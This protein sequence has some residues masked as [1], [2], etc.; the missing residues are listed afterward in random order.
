M[1][2]MKLKY[3]GEVVEVISSEGEGRW[4]RSERLTSRDA[5]HP[6]LKLA[7]QALKP[8]AL[9]ICELDTQYG[10][11]MRVQSVSW[12]YDKD[13]FRGAVVTCLRELRGVPSPLVINTPSLSER[14]TDEVEPTMPRAMSNALDALEQEAEKFVN[15][16]REQADMFA[17]PAA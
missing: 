6:D 14:E 8:L 7:L 10:Q 5:P 3:D 12:S 11:K 15:G 13:G 1:R 17:G 2:I 16:Y 9:E 4:D